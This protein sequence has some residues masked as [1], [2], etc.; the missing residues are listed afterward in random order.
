MKK[1]LSILLIA[2]GIGLVP[3]FAE[4]DSPQGS[5]RLP[6][7]SL[8]DVLEATTKKSGL[9]FVVDEQA[10][11]GV[12]I[13]QQALGEIGYPE[14]LV[15]LR[16]NA[17]AAV[18]VEGLVNIIPVA[19]VREHALPVVDVDDE[20]IGDDEWV[21]VV[22]KVRNTPAVQFVPI[23]RPLLSQPGHLSASPTANALVLVD[24]FANARRVAR[25]VA[26]LDV[27]AANRVD[28]D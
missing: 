27:P 11:A 6:R 13:G 24:R 1:A 9:V 8:M 14:L 17:L 18:R 20:S 2:T 23:L 28:G 22:L 12:V 7:V 21:T 3:A 16:N 15:V 19:R 4:E 26:E 10:P 5:E 25:I